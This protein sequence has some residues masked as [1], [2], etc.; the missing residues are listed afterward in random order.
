MDGKNYFD[1]YCIFRILKIKLFIFPDNKIKFFILQKKNIFTIIKTD[2]ENGIVKNVD[3]NE[4]NLEF[5]EQNAM[6]LF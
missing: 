2:F 3:E 4:E 6:K 5:A 1:K